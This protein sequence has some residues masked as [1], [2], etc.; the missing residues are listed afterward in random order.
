MILKKIIKSFL[1]NNFYYLSQKYFV[2]YYF[3]HIIEIFSEKIENEVN[4]NLI[5]VLLNNTQTTQFFK[6]IYTKKI[7]DLNK[8]IQEFLAKEGYHKSNNNYGK[9]DNVTYKNKKNDEVNVNEIEP[10]IIGEGEEN[11]YNGNNDF[12][13]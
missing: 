12:N 7:E 13:N 3:I 10:L 1:R 8:I 5:N 2:Y 11:I 9:K 6:N 4:E